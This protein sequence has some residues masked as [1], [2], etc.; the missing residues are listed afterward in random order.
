MAVQLSSYERQLV[1]LRRLY[2]DIAP[3]ISHPAT[4]QAQVA[5]TTNALQAVQQQL[6]EKLRALAAR[7]TGDV[8]QTVAPPCNTQ[9]VNVARYSVAYLFCFC[10]DYASLGNLNILA[11]LMLCVLSSSTKNTIYC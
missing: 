5:M 1:A 3:V 7:R 8:T 6:V 9:A 10:N 11:H 4:M 2:A